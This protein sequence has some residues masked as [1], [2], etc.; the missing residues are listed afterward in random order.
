[1]SDLTHDEAARHD[2][3]YDSLHE[4]ADF[5][6]LRRRFRAFVFPA[7]IAFLTWYLLYVVMSNWATDFMDT[8]VVGN[9]NV[10]LVFGLLQFVT[11]FLLAYRLRAVRQQP[12]RPVGTRAR[13]ALR[14]GRSEGARDELG[15][16]HRHPVHRRRA[17]HGRHHVL[18][19]PPDH[20]HHGLL[21]RRAQLLRLPER[22]GHLRRL[23]VGRV[24][25]RHLRRHRAERLRRLP[26]LD[27]LPRRLAGRAAAG[28]RAAAQLRSLHDGR[29]A[30][31][32]DAPAAGAHRRRHVHGR[33]L[34]L[35]PARADGRRRRARGAA[36]RRRERRAS[37]TS[38]SSAS[39]C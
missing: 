31:V 17:R 4:S 23:H 22:P 11:T 19:Q 6:E 38:P 28:G 15:H 39:G 16:P 18:G 30:R 1:M 26:L 7:T 24:V 12:A 27:R 21:R 32:P 2:P 29:P 5:V 35:L 14:R 25:P 10:A 36:A 37:R 33:R 13:A 34:D 3:V 9:I 8:K 20:G